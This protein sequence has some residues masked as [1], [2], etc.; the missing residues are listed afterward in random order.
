MYA[1]VVNVLLLVVSPDP[2]KSPTLSAFQSTDRKP[3][4]L[5]D[6]RLFLFYPTAVGN[7]KTAGLPV[8][9]RA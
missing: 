8:E 7:P 6:A 2:F 3:V 4:R 5:S 1:I 9:C